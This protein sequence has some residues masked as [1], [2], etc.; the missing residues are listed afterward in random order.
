MR[1]ALFR[2]GAILLF[3][4]ALEGLTRKG[5]VSPIFLA[6][7]SSIMMAAW[8]RTLGGELIRL[9]MMT[10]YEAG[11]AFVLASCLGLLLGYLM[12]R[13]TT[14]GQA[15]D[16]LLGAVFASPTILIYP[17]FL[18]FFG[19]SPNAIIAMGTLTGVIPIALNTHQG[20]KEVSAIYVKV[21]KSMNLSAR[22]VT[23][24]ILFPAAAPVIL[25]GLK[26]GLTFVLIVIVAMEFLVEIGGIGVLASR[27]YFWFNT[28][29]LY[30]GIASAMLL[31]MIFLYLLGR[32]K[33]R[34]IIS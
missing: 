14:L 4:A 19:R 8:E 22:Q 7:P 25:G 26:L 31:S 20:L 21:G 27:G 3:L 33:T 32:I 2:W 1:P 6:S 17:I 16:T 23:W 29:E 5:W 28:Q 9:L 13:Y 12:W 11:V 24:H 30:L 34:T 18:V 10:M 15:Y